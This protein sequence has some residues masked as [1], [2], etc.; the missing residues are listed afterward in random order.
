MTELHHKLTKTHN[1]PYNGL[2]AGTE[3]LEDQPEG[4]KNLDAH[5][6]QAHEQSVVETC[7]HPLAQA[8]T[9]D[10]GQDTSEEEE[11]IEEDKR[12]C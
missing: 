7:R 6:G 2:W 1:V 4:V 3:H 12:K 8:L 5:P 10:V 11:Q 9:S